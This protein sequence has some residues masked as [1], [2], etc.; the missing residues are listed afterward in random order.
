MGCTCNARSGSTLIRHL[1]WRMHQDARQ[2]FLACEGRDEGESLPRSL[3]NLTV[4]HLVKD[5][6]IQTTLSCPETAFLGTQVRA[7]GGRLALGT[8][9]PR[10]AAAAGPQPTVNTAIPPLRQKAV[11]TF[12]QM[13]PGLTITDLCQQGRVKFSLLRFGQEGACMNYELLGRC[14]GCQYRHEVCTAT[15]SR[16]ASIAKAMEK[17]LATNR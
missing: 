5:C 9:A 13:Y 1:M 7:P 2:F 17:G 3:L 10:P 8:R 12:N 4:C 6:H 16:Q 14:T 15:E 11:A